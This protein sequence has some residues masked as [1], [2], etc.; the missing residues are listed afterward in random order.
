MPKF[1]EL[2]VGE[3]DGDRGI[4]HVNMDQ[5]RFLRPVPSG[6]GTTIVFDHDESLIVEDHADYILTL[7]QR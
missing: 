5:V 2:C 7:A 3:C 1:V 4:V 6:G